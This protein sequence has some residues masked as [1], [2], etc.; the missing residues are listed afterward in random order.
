MYAMHVRAVWCACLWCAACH[1]Y[2]HCLPTVLIASSL[3]VIIILWVSQ[4]LRL[5]RVSVSVHIRV[6]VEACRVNV[7]GTCALQ[8]IISRVWLNDL[9]LGV[10]ERSLCCR[11][12]SEITTVCLWQFLVIVIIVYQFW[13]S[14][15]VFQ[16]TLIQHNMDFWCWPPQSE[17]GLNWRL[18]PSRTIV[19]T[20][21]GLH[22]ERN[23]NTWFKNT[24]IML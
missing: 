3:I 22:N 20:W 11:N 17:P 16:A 9:L 8:Y 18:T 7:H 15:I 14:C 10:D 19:W 21:Q 23:M 1:C 2:C 4:W 6:N 5:V 13:C 24:C 12:L